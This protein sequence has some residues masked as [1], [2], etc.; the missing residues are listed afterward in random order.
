MSETSLTPTR[1]TLPLPRRAV[2]AAAEEA[3]QAKQVAE[4]VP[5]FV[6]VN[7]VDTE[8]ASE[9]RSHKNKR[10]DKPLPQTDP[11]ARNSA[12]FAR[13]SF[14]LV[15]ARRASSQNAQQQQD[16]YKQGQRGSHRDSSRTYAYE[17]HA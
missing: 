8:V 11:E 3:G 9:Q 15:R 6:I 1:F 13:R 14:G 12:V 7:L 16:N 10:R 2:A 5:T 17:A 4:V